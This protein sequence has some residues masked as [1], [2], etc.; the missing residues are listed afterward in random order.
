MHRMR[1]SVRT[2]QGRLAKPGSSRFVARTCFLDSIPRKYPST[3]WLS[4]SQSSNAYIRHVPNS[5]KGFGRSSTRSTLII[6]IGFGAALAVAFK[7]GNVKFEVQII[8]H[9]ASDSGSRVNSND[10]PAD[11]VS[12]LQ[13]EFEQLRRQIIFYSDKDPEASRNTI[14]RFI[15]F[16]ERHPHLLDLDS[17]NGLMFREHYVNSLAGELNQPDYLRENDVLINACKRRLE[18]Y[19]RRGVLNLPLQRVLPMFSNDEQREER[20]ELHSTGKPTDSEE[21]KYIFQQLCRAYGRLI[22]VCLSDASSVYNHETAKETTETLLSLL[23]VEFAPS[24]ERLPM[25]GREH[26]TEFDQVSICYYINDLSSHFRQ[27]TSSNYSPELA[28]RCLRP[29]AE[30]LQSM[31]EAGLTSPCFR[32]DCLQSIA[33]LILDLACESAPEG[34]LT[35]DEERQHLEEAKRVQQRVLL[36]DAAV[37]PA[38]RNRSCDQA[39]VEGLI[40]MAKIGWKCGEETAGDL[41]LEK[42]SRLADSINSHLYKEVIRRID[43]DPSK[44]AMKHWEPVSQEECNRLCASDGEENEER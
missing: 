1:T 3:R 28:L 12:A 22:E 24:F 7:Y 38:K 39:C 16:V 5:T 20:R 31:E 9:D 14:E 30:L 29:M 6:L 11:D 41:E 18:E 2:V 27:N 25:K 21:R 32:I 19:D 33:N 37:D 43:K 36:L 34:L 40:S 23:E 26:S 13:E 35:T 15:R 4:S 10:P 17:I 8:Q 42:A 44:T